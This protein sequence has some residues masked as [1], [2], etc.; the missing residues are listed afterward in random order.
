MAR[1]RLR[2]GDKHYFMY[3]PL[4]CIPLYIPLYLYHLPI[5]KE[6]PALLGV[7][8]YPTY[9]SV[10]GNRG[11]CYYP[12]ILKPLPN[13]SQLKNYPQTN[14]NHLLR[15]RNRSRE[16]FSEAIFS[17]PDYYSQAIGP[18]F[19][20][21]SLRQWEGVATPVLG[22][23]S[24]ATGP[25]FL[26]RS[27]RRWEGVGHMNDGMWRCSPSLTTSDEG[28]GVGI[29]WS[30]G[31]SLAD[32]PQSLSSLATTRFIGSKSI[33]VCNGT[34]PDLSMVVVRLF[35]SSFGAAMVVAKDDGGRCF[36]ERH[37]ILQGWNYNFTSCWVF[38][39][40]LLDTH[41]FVSC[42]DYMCN[43]QII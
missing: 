18:C 20:H 38:C 10:K 33:L 36:G 11:H 22:Y 3:I 34:L 28:G 12:F 14:R 8:Q 9:N 17:A 37:G 29:W 23:Y 35:V 16:N 41:M 27:L 15:P 21:R 32:M 6:R 5:Y 42:S 31:K 1:L 40:S 2:E 30:R 4:I 39:A 19:L 26:H 25:C 13:F 7:V 24:Q 43:Q